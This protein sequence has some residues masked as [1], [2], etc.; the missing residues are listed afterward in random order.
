MK[1]GYM[2]SE[3]WITAFVDIVA[4]FLA[5]LAVRG[6][7]AG[8]EAAIWVSLA[9]ALVTA[10]AP[11]VVAVVTKSYVDGRARLKIALAHA[12]VA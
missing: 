12:D 9:E 11:V 7:I 4:A 6:L 1:P 8:D 10:I 2:T 3:F 5:V